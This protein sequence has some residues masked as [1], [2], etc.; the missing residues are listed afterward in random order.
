MRAAVEAEL[1]EATRKDL[2]RTGAGLDGKQHRIE[3]S[4]LKA[5][6]GESGMRANR[7]W[8][9][10]YGAATYGMIARV[11]TA[12]GCRELNPTLT[13]VVEMDGAL[14]I[15]LVDLAIRLRVRADS[16]RGVDEIK[17]LHETLSKSGNMLAQ[18]VIEWLVYERLVFYNTDVS[19]MQS[20]CQQMGFRN[21]P[22]AAF[23]P[24]RKRYSGR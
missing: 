19:Q 18:F 4:R 2:A 7:F 12:L 17:T 10:M 13:R 6:W 21:V 9:T 8:F 1:R 5:M 24:S 15:Q 11:A 23:D 22:S 20:L 14:P 16:I 3:R